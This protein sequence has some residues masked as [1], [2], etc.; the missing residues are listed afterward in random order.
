MFLVGAGE[1]TQQL[2]PL[3]ALAEEVG[4]VHSTLG[5]CTTTQHLVPGIQ[6]PPQTSKVST[7]NMVH[8]IYTH[9]HTHKINSYVLCILMEKFII[10]CVLSR[11]CSPILKPKDALYKLMII[12]DKALTNK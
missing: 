2:R 8:S 5:C 1:M 11:V 3:T 10:H 9:A 4:L 7:M 6:Y 12:S